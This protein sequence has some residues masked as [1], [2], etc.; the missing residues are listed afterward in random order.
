MKKN[1]EYF[2]NNIVSY[3]NIYPIIVYKSVKDNDHIQVNLKNPNSISWNSKFAS[4]GTRLK[5]IFEKMFHLHQPSNSFTNVN[6]SCSSRQNLRRCMVKYI[7]E[8][9]ANGVQ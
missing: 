8:C 1:C 5:F 7:L 6:S 3:Y 2:I 9:S 4:I